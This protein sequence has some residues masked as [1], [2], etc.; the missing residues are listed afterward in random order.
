MLRVLADG[1]GHHQVNN[2][3]TAAALR[4]QTRPFASSRDTQLQLQKELR[5]YPHAGQYP[6]SPGTVNQN[7]AGID[8]MQ[9]LASEFTPI[10]STSR[11]HSIQEQAPQDSE[12]TQGDLVSDDDP[13]SSSPTPQPPLR[14][15]TY[16]TSMSRISAYER[17]LRRQKVSRQVSQ[18]EDRRLQKWF[19]AYEPVASSR[20][21]NALPAHST[22][23]SGEAIGVAQCRKL[24]RRGQLLQGMTVL[25]ELCEKN[26]QAQTY[27]PPRRQRRIFQPF[28]HMTPQTSRFNRSRDLDQLLSNHLESHLPQD[29]LIS[30]DDL[31]S[32]ASDISRVFSSARELDQTVSEDDKT[33]L[34]RPPVL[35]AEM[36]PF[37][38]PKGLLCAHALATLFDSTISLGY[39]PPQALSAILLSCFSQA[40]PSECFTGAVELVLELYDWDGIE[41]AVLSSIVAG[42][43]RIGEMD[44]A[45]RVLAD[46]GTANAMSTGDQIRTVDGQ[47][48]IALNGWSFEGAIWASM[49]RGHVLQGDIPGA[50][51][52]LNVFRSVR[53]EIKAGILPVELCPP[54]TATPYLTLMTGLE[55]RTLSQ[56]DQPGVKNTTETDRQISEIL[57]S[58]KQDGIQRS[59]QVLNF[60]AKFRRRRGKL[61]ESMELLQGIDN[62]ERTHPCDHPH[63]EVITNLQQRI[64][65]ATQIAKTLL[66]N[67]ASD[68]EKK[69]VLQVNSKWDAHTYQELFDT[70][71]YTTNANHDLHPTYYLQLSSKTPLLPFTARNVL[72]C[73]LYQYLTSSKR[74]QTILNSVTLY[75]ALRCLLHSS[76][77]DYSLGL[78]V[79]QMYRVF[80]VEV[81]TMRLFSVVTKAIEMELVDDDVGTGKY[82]VASGL[83]P[84]NGHVVHWARNPGH[85]KGGFQV[86]EGDDNSPRDGWSVDFDRHQGVSGSQT[87]SKVSQGRQQEI[88]IQSMVSLKNLL[89]WAISQRVEQRIQLDEWINDT[90]MSEHNDWITS[91]LKD[92]YNSLV[93]NQTPPLPESDGTVTKVM[94]GTTSQEWQTSLYAMRQFWTEFDSKFMKGQLQFYFPEEDEVVHVG[95]KKRSPGRPR[96]KHDFPERDSGLKKRPRGRPRKI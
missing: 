9:R 37:D 74:S 83:D 2:R 42:Y 25:M 11:S 77:K 1:G 66:S 89:R 69:I 67:V 52:W 85:T 92:R 28:R 29:Q 84:N 87:I 36:H 56:Q 12:T 91:D 5:G 33:Q 22:K 93:A 13:S 35:P 62:A 6:S 80:N 46:F 50:Y 65:R 53:K 43:G 58:M 18:E 72:Q 88:K 41:L 63:Q 8:T 51:R 71:I 40:M 4:V 39:D 82:F 79:L 75:K 61:V 44:I 16:D 17:K 70:L 21:R 86:V 26:I 19:T 49:I 31:S 10:A 96:K 14:P 57:E 81:D 76:I 34:W 68:K 94:A 73:L 20:V 3:S 95:L 15:P 90:E 54:S 27:L 24:I 64:Q 48:P 60:L 30:P 32:I 78:A 59:V 45:E 47:E 7:G 55:L 38:L 23:E